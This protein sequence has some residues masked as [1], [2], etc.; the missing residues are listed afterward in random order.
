MSPGVALGVQNANGGVEFE[1]PAGERHQHRSRPRG[2]GLLAYGA[3]VQIGELVRADHP[4]AGMARRDLAGL[5]LRQPRRLLARPFA[6][7][8]AFVDAGR[9]GHE[10]ADQP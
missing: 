6:G 10:I 3:P 4:C 8:R 5:R 2:R 7:E 9:V 1:R